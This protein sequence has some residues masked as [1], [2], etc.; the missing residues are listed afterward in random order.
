MMFLSNVES[1]RPLR[2]CVRFREYTPKGSIPITSCKT[3]VKHSTTAVWCSALKIVSVHSCYWI[4]ITYLEWNIVAQ[5][6][7]FEHSAV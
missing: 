1:N 4:I 7:S 2:H 3:R 6:L 5:R